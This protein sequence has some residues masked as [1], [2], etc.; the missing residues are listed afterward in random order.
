MAGIKTLDDVNVAG[1]RVLVRVDF[2]VPVRNG[3]VTDASRIERVLPTIRELKEK[4]A[5]VVLISHFGRP[6]GKIVRE[7]SL[8]PVVRALQAALGGEQVAFAS[9][10]IGP[11]ADQVT[12][13]LK[14]GE[15]ALLENLR[16]H[17]GEERNDPV[18]ARALAANG[19]IY[20]D[21][22]FAAAHRAHASVDAITKF[23]PAVVGRLMEQEI[24]TLT[25]ILE[26]PARPLAAIIG[27]A[28]IS[29]KLDLLGNLLPKVDVMIVGGAMANTF[30]YANGIDVGELM[31]EYKMADEA[32]R[33]T[34]QAK[35]RGCEI[36]L[37]VDAVVA[38]DLKPDIPDKTVPV[39]QIPKGA[40]ILDIGPESAK[41]IVNKL[42]A[43]KSLVWN[44]PLGAFETPPFEMGTMVVADAV[45]KL[46]KAG[47]LVSVA[48]GGDTVA[49]LAMA[50]VLG[51]FTY[52]STAGGAFLEWLEGKE[53]PGIAALKASKG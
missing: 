14:D 25:R 40:M 3:V 1:K 18:F 26:Q 15:V 41:Q 12:K 36:L 29:T 10:C 31:C 9:D 22:A 6:K 46:T 39:T 23:L 5:R 43:C 49:A 32:R 42:T 19:Q 37:P 47:K 44:G 33:V 2:N 50:G 34:A 27:G 51:D 28:K 4:G 7:M 16:Y 53:L 13:R 21:D 30:L 8:R 48:G 45:A 11:P 35:Q 24:T 20:V 17:G 52:V 38:A